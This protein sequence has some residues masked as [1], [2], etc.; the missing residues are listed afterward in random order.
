MSPSVCVC[1]WKGAW[2]LLCC[3][4][5]DT[6]VLNFRAIR[7]SLKAWSAHHVGAG[8]LRLVSPDVHPAA[9]CCFM[10]FYRHL[11]Y[12][13]ILPLPAGIYLPCSPCRSARHLPDQLSLPFRRHLPDLLSPPFRRHLPSLLSLPLRRHL[14]SCSACR[15]AGTYLTRSPC[16][17]SRNPPLLI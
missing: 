17:S 6:P 16:R 15:S 2:L 5:S 7:L 13:L 12:L 1:V 4:R 3:S 14:P 11:P 8:L 9:S 10:C